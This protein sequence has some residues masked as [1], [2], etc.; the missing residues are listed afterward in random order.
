MAKIMY[1]GLVME[2]MYMKPEEV[3]KLLRV[4]TRA[5]YGWLREGRLESYRPF[6]RWLITPEQVEKFVKGGASVAAPG[7]DPAPVAAPVVSPPAAPVS[8]VS[9]PV[10]S[11]PNANPLANMNRKKNGRR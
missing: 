2:E 8:A 10:S 3:A 1:N 7:V 5:V 11:R 6:G 9:M 4:S